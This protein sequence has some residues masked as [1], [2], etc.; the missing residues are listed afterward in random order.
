MYLQHW[1]YKLISSFQLQDFAEALNIYQFLLGRRRIGEKA[2]S[3]EKVLFVTIASLL[4]LIRYQDNRKQRNA[5]DLGG[6]YWM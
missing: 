1:S 4:C 2:H 3:Y 6:A 5:Q